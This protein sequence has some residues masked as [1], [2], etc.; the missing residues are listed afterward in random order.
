MEE[1]IGTTRAK[2]GRMEIDREEVEVSLQ[3]L[4][5]SSQNLD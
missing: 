2:L 5:T 1:Q 3:T 4:V